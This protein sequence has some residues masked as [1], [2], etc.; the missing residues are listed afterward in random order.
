LN[1]LSSI[2]ISKVFAKQMAIATIVLLTL[3]TMRD[4]TQTGWFI[5]YEES[6]ISKTTVIVAGTLEKVKKS[7]EKLPT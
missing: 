1:C 6:G 2:D 5:M 3:A 7:L 4:A